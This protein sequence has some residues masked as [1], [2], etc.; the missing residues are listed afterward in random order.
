MQLRRAREL[1]MNI[2]DDPNEYPF[3]FSTFATAVAMCAVYGYHPKPRN[4]PMVTIVD[5]FLQVAMPGLS[6]GKSFILKVFPFLL[7]LPAWFPGSWINREAREACIWSE[8]MVEIP[9]EFARREQTLSKDHINIGMVS[10]HINL[11]EQ[12]EDT[13]YRSEYER[14]LKH[15]SATTLLASG[16]T[17]STVLMTFTL[18][19]IEH[20]HVWKRAQA[21]ID[22]VIGTERLPE[23]E[24]RPS[25]PYVDAIVRETL[26]WRPPTPLNLPHAATHSDIYEGYYIPKGASIMVN[27]WGISRDEARY[28]DAHKFMPER[29]LNSQG[30]LTADD[31]AEYVFGYGRR[32][33]PGR[34]TADASV[35][36]AIMTM[37]ATLDFKLATD[38]NEN[39]I[40]FKATFTNGFTDRPNTF[41]CK[42]TPRPHVSREVLELAFSS[43]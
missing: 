9:Y 12:F 13:A 8:K 5:T 26:R 27:L 4:D 10:E 22:A 2:I 6:P 31:P 35:W 23:Y 38:A 39:D 21:A 28:P 37:L 42:L 1:I 11:M 33:C 24:D 3:H 30:M 7:H 29:F 19:M 16:E 32:K 18:A 17:T 25:L 40:T 43:E 36:I 14:A 20:P 41:P 15:A 34:H